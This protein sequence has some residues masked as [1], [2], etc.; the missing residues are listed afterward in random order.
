MDISLSLLSNQIGQSGPTVS[1]HRPRNV[2]WFYFWKVIANFHYVGLQVLSVASTNTVVFLGF[3]AVLSGE[4]LLM[5]HNYL[6]PP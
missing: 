3:S 5:F 6:L 1:S 4:S 2:S